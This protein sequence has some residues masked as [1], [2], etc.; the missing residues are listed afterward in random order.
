[1]D[2]AL[3]SLVEAGF[4]KSVTCL[5]L[6]D[7]PSVSNAL[8]DLIEYHCMIKVKVAIQKWVERFRSLGNAPGV[9]CYLE[10][11]VCV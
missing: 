7:A 10:T 5:T 11:I 8:V 9:S 3:D 4:R 6:D 1:M 2:E